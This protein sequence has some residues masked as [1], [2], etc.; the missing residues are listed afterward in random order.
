MPLS[1]AKLTVYTAN[2]T[3][4]AAVFSDASLATPLTNPVV[5]DS[6]GVLPEIFCASGGLFDLLLKTSAGVLVRSYEDVPS[7]GSDSGA[8]SLDF[9]SARFTVRADGSTVRVEA[10]DPSPDNTGGTMEIGGW[11]GTQA[12]SVTIDAVV[13]DT[14]GR[15]KEM[16]KK[17]PAIVITDATAFTGVTNVAIQ[18]VNNPTGCR[19]W[20][21][22]VFDLVTSAVSDIDLNGTLSY[23]GGGSYKTGASDYAYQGGG[24]AGVTDTWGGDDSDTRLMIGDNIRSLTNKPITLKIRVL[25]PDSG[26]NAT[27]VWTELMG[28]Q[29]AS[30]VP[31]WQTWRAFGIGGYGR[32]THLKI[33]ATSGNIAGS[34]RVTALRGFGET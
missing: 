19:A 2:T 31:V 17:I 18:L 6:A 4:L 20:D 7:L 13:A 28:W 11:N 12:D 14:T 30:T 33:S 27:L 26:L 23:D 9:T 25:S 8:F 22:D 3:T 29:N 5:A 1:G 10:G 15:Y 34:Y 21:I 16:G 32:A 24:V